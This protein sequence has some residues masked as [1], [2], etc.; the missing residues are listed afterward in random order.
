MNFLNNFYTEVET[1][2]LSISA[3]QASGF[4][5]TIADDFNPIHNAD[6]RR[7]CVPGDLLFAIALGKYGLHQDMAFQFMDLIGADTPL[8][9]PAAK[10]TRS[11]VQMQVVNH[12]D[13]PVLGINFG[14]EGSYNAARIEQLIKKYVV[15]SGQNFPHILVPLM[16]QHDVMINPKRPLVIYESMS[17]HFEQLEFSSLEIVLEKT[18]LKVE[19]KRG[20]AQLYFSLNSGGQTIG[21]GIKNLVLSGLR[22]YDEQAV[23]QMCEDYMASKATYEI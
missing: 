11:P 23:N 14:G 12:K 13:K 6:S 5:K 17:I 4:A 9:Y 10:D 2:Q 7:F 20:S 18:S 21:S 16:Q 1:G 19:G 8:I 3:D 22:E 15:F